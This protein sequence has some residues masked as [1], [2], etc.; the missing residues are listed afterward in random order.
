MKTIVKE[1]GTFIIDLDKTKEYY[2]RHTLCTCCCCRNYYAQIRAF[3][4]ELAAFL[5]EFGV[6]IARP[7]ELGSVEM[8]GYIDYL[9]AG[10]TVTGRMEADRVHKTMVGG[11]QVAISKGGTSFDLF[12]HEQ[13]EPCFF[14]SVEGISLPWVLEEPFPQPQ[15]FPGK[16]K[17]F[18][19][20]RRRT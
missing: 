14:I 9:F 15:S 20:K 5:A 17:N 12:P 13:K 6:D 3:A 4:P 1:N 11:L 16:G 10:Y 7:D 18:L 19:K 8:D 2:S